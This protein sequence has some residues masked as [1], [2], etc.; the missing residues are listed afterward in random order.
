MSNGRNYIGKAPEP[1]YPTGEPEVFP[2]LF[3]KKTNGELRATM[4]FAS[5]FI[6]GLCLGV[7]LAT[8][9]ITLLRLLAS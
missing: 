7:G 9:G 5:G 6:V 8:A 2:D 1:D 3:R 4:A